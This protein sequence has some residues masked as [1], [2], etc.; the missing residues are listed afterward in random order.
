MAVKFTPDGQRVLSGVS[1][2]TICGWD[3]ITGTM[4]LVL[5][6]HDDV[7]RTISVSSNGKF[8]Q[9]DFGMPLLAGNA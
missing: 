6:G 3:V 4:T 2:N 7:I 1:D 8:L 5:Q 9:Y